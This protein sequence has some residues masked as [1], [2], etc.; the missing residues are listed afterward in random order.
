MKSE[1]PQPVKP[2]RLPRA[3]RKGSTK[4]D[5][6]DISEK[7]LKQLEESFSVLTTIMQNFAKESKSANKD[8]LSKLKEQEKLLK[9]IDKGVQS[10]EVKIHKDSAAIFQSIDKNVKL[11]AES[12][13][14]MKDQQL[15]AD[16]AEEQKAE[17][18]KE[19]KL[20]Q[21][22]RAEKQEELLAKIVTKLDTLDVGVA[23][24]TDS[25]GGILGMLSK[26]LPSLL[27]LVIGG[28]SAIAGTIA[29]LFSTLLPALLPIIVAGLAA[30]AGYL[31]FKNVV[32][33]WMDERQKAV[34]D[35]L[36]PVLGGP[37]IASEDVVTDT[38][39][40]VFMREDANTGQM[41]YVSESQMK[42]E[43]ASMPEEDRKKLESGESPISF[44]AAKNTIDL[45]SRQYMNEPITSGKT[46]EQINQITKEAEQAK[47]ELPPNMKAQGEY[48]KEITRFDES[49]RNQLAQTMT[50]WY[51]EG[52]PETSLAG[53][54]ETFKAVLE[55]LYNEHMSIINRIR[56]D[57]RLK[58]EDKSE[59]MKISPLFD[60]AFTMTTRTSYIEGK[61]PD[62]DTVWVL[63]YDLPNGQGLTFDWAN[64]LPSLQENRALI[65]SEFGAPSGRAEALK[66]KYDATEALE[67]Q[68][69]LSMETPP[70]AAS[71][72]VVFPKTGKGVLTNI[73]EDMKPEAVVP[74]D[75]Y[76]IQSKSDIQPVDVSDKAVNMMRQSYFEEK[77]ASSMESQRPI[78]VNNV[79]SGGG[80]GGTAPIN[81]QFQ[82]SLAKTFDNVFEE[83]L[84]KN[85]TL[86]VVT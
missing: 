3:S 41:S 70:E 77:D 9:S 7:V 63:G 85:L 8:T 46:I 35:S 53:S 28:L 50:S 33:P 36:K 84:R 60:E 13:Q 83:I 15:K 38:G 72:A 27:P 23:T 74:L 54:R 14:L 40:K 11:V 19:E 86:S 73:S 17:E 79:R 78:V 5:K 45:Q 21:Q 57:E 71:G 22:E 26:L 76:V 32:E 43:I 34:E 64:S 51:K 4:Q 67:K 29:G 2:K 25:G 10:N 42:S 69:S 1:N 80:E 68:Q 81:Y 12:N 48:S 82:T 75:E 52:G 65:D 37:G 61:D 55:K 58:P 49:F 20:V 66:Q 31:L 62:Y 39:E 24:V 47:A 56:S 18:L 6:S 16:F 44:V 59:L 30:G